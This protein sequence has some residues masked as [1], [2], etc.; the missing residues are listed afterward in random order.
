MEN[1]LRRLK[2]ATVLLIIV[3]VIG[4]VGYSTLADLDPLDAIY[5][6]VIT[7]TTT[8]YSD[9]AAEDHVKPFT[10]AL[11]AVGFVVIAL[12]VSM[13][14]AT[15]IEAAILSAIG[16]RRLE[17]SIEKLKDHM[18]VCGY[19]RFGK[20]VAAP[21]RRSGSPF[22]IVEIDHETADDA[23]E[24]GLLVINADATEE[25]SL[26]RAG[27][28][29]ARG[30]LTTL[31]TDAANLYVTL[32]ARQMKP[33][34]AIAAAAMNQRA[35]AKLKAAGAD[36]VVSPYEL[37]GSW[38]AQLI[39][40][41]TVADFME[42]ATGANPLDF[43]MEQQGVDTASPLCGQ[44][45]TSSHIGRDLGVIVVAVQKTDGQMVTN[46][47]PDTILEAGDTLVSLGTRGNLARLETLAQGRGPS[48][49]QDQ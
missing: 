27:I 30:L 13:L 9:L 31:G 39:L 28:E 2:L 21:L 41:P 38:M 16:R 48:R 43:F 14:T 19:G 46:P 33:G 10:I 32:T 24:Q 34:I 25:D 1:I 42:I 7:I 40:S 8:G 44:S 23:K 37:G 35:V 36:R 3:F 12:F 49:T 15:V 5:Q 47:R 4:V 17:R 45:L 11:L 20:S 6:T 26:T 22:V 29:R 18:I